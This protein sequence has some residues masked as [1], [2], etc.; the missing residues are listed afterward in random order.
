MI[1]PILHQTHLEYAFAMIVNFQTDK[2]IIQTM[3][4]WIWAHRRF[5][6]ISQMDQCY[7]HQQSGMQHLNFVHL[8]HSTSMD[9]VLPVVYEWRLLILIQRER[10]K[11]KHHSTI[12]I[13]LMSLRPTLPFTCNHTELSFSKSHYKSVIPTENG[14]QLW[15]RVIVSRRS[16]PKWS[17]TSL[18]SLLT[19]SLFTTMSFFFNV[20]SRDPHGMGERQP[21]TTVS[22]LQE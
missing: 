22:D 11:P 15:P 1:F 19:H 16:D 17:S 14:T 13:L 3:S 9:W 2:G 10:K 12:S 7:S 20:K 21:P 4:T 8:S 18:D 5:M 6:Q